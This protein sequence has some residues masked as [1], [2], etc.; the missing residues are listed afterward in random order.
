M[1]KVSAELVDLLEALL[2]QDELAR[3]L[4]REGWSVEL[5]KHLSPVEYTAPH[6]WFHDLVRLVMQHGQAPAL[7]AMVRRLRP[8]RSAE[9]EA[10]E[11]RLERGS[12]ATAPVNPPPQPRPAPQRRNPI[13]VLHLSD[14]H[15]SAKAAWGQTPVLTGNHDVERSKVNRAA[16]NLDA[17]ILGEGDTTLAE[18]MHDDE[19]RLLLLG[20]RAAY[21]D[22]A[23]GIPPRRRARLALRG[24]DRGLVRP[25]RRPHDGRA[26][27]QPPST[28]SPLLSGC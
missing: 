17:D 18:L 13:R 22:F 5:V 21:R 14:L 7:L 20:R 2:K 27:G 12:L 10:L 16:R 25:P 11:R 1:S 19:Q 4:E 15:F 28:A 3:A 9:I 8:A 26:I 23:R 24:G 6:V